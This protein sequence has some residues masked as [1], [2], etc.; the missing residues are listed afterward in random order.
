MSATA[1]V[2]VV[3]AGMSGLECAVAIVAGGV[4]DVLVVDAGGDRHTQLA[5]SASP[6]H[7]T[8]PPHYQRQ[9]SSPA[10]G[11][12]SLRWHGVVLRLE[13]WALADRA[14]PETVRAALC[15]GV[16][17]GAA[18][19]E[20][21]ERDL[22]GWAGDS[23]TSDDG[24][25][26]RL[27]VPV[28]GEARAVPLAVRRG[29]DD[30]WLAYT[31]LDRCRRWLDRADRP[32]VPRVRAGTR[33]LDL[34][35]RAGRVTGVWLGDV[36]TGEVE[37]VSSGNVVLASGTLDNTRLVAQSLGGD[38]PRS[39]P[40]LNDHLVQGFVVR[41]PV[42]A[43]GWS[44]PRDAF[45]YEAGGSGTRSNLFAR[46]R[47][48]PGN[49][50]EVLLDVWAM[51]EQVRSD[52]NSVAF[53]EPRDVPWRGVVT[54]GL[55]TR[56][57]EV[58]AAQ[59]QRLAQVWTDLA[60]APL[61]PAGS[62][63]FFGAPVTFQRACAEVM[64]GSPGVPVGYSWPL[65]T[66]DHE[67]GTLPLGGA[68]VDETGGLTALAGGYVVGPATLPRSGAANPSLTTLALARWTALRLVAG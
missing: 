62:P 35:T 43:L 60:G 63:A 68:Y 67:S 4:D 14:W 54:P 40:G 16:N 59:R 30:G 42:A 15:D 55:A 13:D 47:R 65:G 52:H 51:G 28:L 31:P 32:G 36:R 6:W 46:V 45:G 23:L 20:E 39:F 61:G 24:T 18:L 19:Y 29:P 33:A 3:G 2:V 34:V 44:S 48:V 10:V 25:A 21:V 58:L 17:T 37:L 8:A 50:G 38:Q 41:Q 9:E 66:V 7:T 27:L 57:D 56:D 11:G 53:P 1:D 49:V 64:S 22:A 26:A 12:R 5:G